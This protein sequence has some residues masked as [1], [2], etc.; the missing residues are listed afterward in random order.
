MTPFEIALFVYGIIL[1]LTTLSIVYR[2]VV[3]PTILDRA[4]STDMLVVLV[5]M[6]MALYSAQATDNWAGPAMLS[7]TGL[8]FI[9]T[10]TFARFVAREDAVYAR[11]HDDEEPEASTG[12]LQALHLDHEGRTPDPANVVVLDP[13]EA[14][15]RN[16]W[17]QDEIPIVPEEEGR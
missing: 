9:G 12:P 14:A 1:A 11:D 2:M 16:V 17:D 10:V 13:S 7:L 5:V 3:G 8:A 6:A 4:V 15:E